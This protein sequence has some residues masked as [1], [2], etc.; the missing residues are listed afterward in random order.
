MKIRDIVFVDHLKDPGLIAWHSR[1]HSHQAAE[2]E[3]HYFVSGSGQ[4]M[5]DDIKYGIRRSQVFLC[6]PGRL[7]AI[8]PASDDI[9]LTY[10]AVLFEYDAERDFSGSRLEC[11]PDGVSFPMNLKLSMR[12]PFERLKSRYT[13]GDAFTRIAVEHELAA[14]ICDMIA[15][16]RP[17]NAERRPGREGMKASY[18]ARA[19]ELMSREL[20]SSP[21]LAT[22]AER[23]GIS[24][25]YLIKVFRKETGVTPMNWLRN[26]KHEAGIHYL[27]NTDLSMKEIAACLGYSSQYHFSRNFKAES[28]Q[29]PTEY[30]VRYLRGNPEGYG[31]RMAQKT[32]KEPRSETFRPFGFPAHPDSG[33]IPD[34]NLY[35]GN[36]AI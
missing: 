33:I 20:S 34:N 1:K 27:T 31:A 36:H 10:Y 26:V 28:G 16:A 5:L 23:L 30:R 4:F 35:G 11:L 18:V 22:L 8:I 17:A 25:E 3:L 13:S 12:M 15:A 29:C 6:L 7:H 14:L 2:F 32:G 24:Q 9:P 19:T 21:D